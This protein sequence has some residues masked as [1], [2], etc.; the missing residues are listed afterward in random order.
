MQNTVL[1]GLSICEH[2]ISSQIQDTL[3]SSSVES[4][5]VTEVEGRK[6]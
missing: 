2:E 5:V 4:I 6:H 3:F 1:N